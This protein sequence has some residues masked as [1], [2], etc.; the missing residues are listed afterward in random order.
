VSRVQALAAAFR[1]ANDLIERRLRTRNV[2][3]EMVFA[4]SPHN[5]VS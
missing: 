2:H 1:A 5:N 4:L 3:S